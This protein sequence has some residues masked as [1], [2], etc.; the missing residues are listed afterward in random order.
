MKIVWLILNTL[1]LDVLAEVGFGFL[2]PSNHHTLQEAGGGGAAQV[3][4]V[5]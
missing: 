2:L 4:R 3:F 1:I 5:R